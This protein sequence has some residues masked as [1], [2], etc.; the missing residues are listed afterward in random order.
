MQD[1]SVTEAKLKADY[2]NGRIMEVHEEIPN[3]DQRIM[4]CCWACTEKPTV[5][6]TVIKARLVARGFEE[7]SYVLHKDSPTC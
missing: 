6:E 7:E 5:N 3:E 2:R 1:L 4:S